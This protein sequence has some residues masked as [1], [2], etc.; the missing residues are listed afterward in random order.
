MITI[1]YAQMIGLSFLLWAIVHF[2]TV[3]YQVHKEETKRE[4]EERYGKET[5]RSKSV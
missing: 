1:T 5:E 2:I 3:L 4:L